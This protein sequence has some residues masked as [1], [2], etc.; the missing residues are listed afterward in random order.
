MPLSTHDTARPRVA[1]IGVGAFGELHIEAFRRAG[2]D[3][4]AIADTAPDR[5][6]H[7]AERHNVPHWY[8]DGRALLDDIH[9]AA[10]SIATATGGAQLAITAVYQQCRVL[11]EKPIATTERQA[12]ELVDADPLNMIQPAHILRFEPSIAELRRQIRGGAVGEILAISSQ[13][14]RENGHAARYHQTHPALLT[15]V[16]DIDLAQWFTGT[17][18]DEVSARSS[19]NFLTATIRAS[20]SSVWSIRTSWLLPAAAPIADRFEIYGSDGIATLEV[21]GPNIRITLGSPDAPPTVAIFDDLAILTA[22]F[23]HFLSRLTSTVEP[24]V[25]LGEA[26]HGIAIAEAMINSA[27]TDGTAI[28]LDA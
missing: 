27:N 5:A 17:R 13:R 7:V 15:A 18:A 3:V 14:N 28:R 16:H 26:R 23:R 4:V 11:L 2:A 20:D 8:T 1:V 24:I 25:T 22:E 6:H 12:R 9:P 19:S 21:A 10:V